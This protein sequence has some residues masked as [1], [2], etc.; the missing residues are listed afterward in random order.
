MEHHVIYS[1]S[2][3]GMGIASILPL[4]KDSYSARI[5]VVDISESGSGLKEMGGDAVDSQ[6]KEHPDGH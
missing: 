4:L 1:C 6:E 2:R 3:T 5:G